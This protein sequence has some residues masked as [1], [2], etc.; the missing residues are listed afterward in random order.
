MLKIKEIF[1]PILRESRD[2][3]NL[4]RTYLHDLYTMGAQNALDK[5]LIEEEI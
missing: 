1:P 3:V 4:L 2:F 5:A